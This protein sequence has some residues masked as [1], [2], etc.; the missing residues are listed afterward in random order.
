MTELV[1]RTRR[2][3]QDLDL[4]ELAGPD[5]VLLE[6][7]RVG[8]AGRG[9]AARVP[10]PSIEAALGAIEVDDQVGSPGTG[11]VAFGALPFRPDHGERAGDP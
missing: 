11:P 1:A 5:G 8:L 10:L 7:A 3:D 6:R 4:L 2:V 9:V